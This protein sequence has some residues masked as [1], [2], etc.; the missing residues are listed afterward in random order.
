MLATP[1][2]ALF[3]SSVFMN[4]S[5]TGALSVAVGDALVYFPE[6]QKTTALITLVILMGALQLVFGLLRLGSLIRFVS[7]S[8]MTGFITGIA[9]LIILGA[10]PNLTGYHSPHHSEFLKLADTLL[11]LNQADPATLVVGLITIGLIVGFDYTPLRKFSMI[12]ALAVVTLLTFFLSPLLSIDSLD[13]VG[14]IAVIPRSMPLPILPDVTMVPTLILPALAIGII[15]LIQGAGVGQSYPNPDGKYPNVSR[16]FAGQ[17]LGNIAAGFFQGIPGGGSMS[18]T[19]VSVNAGAQSRWANILAGVFII[20]IVL[21]LADIVTLIPMAA[22]A[23]LLVVVGFQNLQPNKINIV[24]N[25]GLIARSAMVLTLLAT[26]SM[27]LQFAILVGVAISIMLYVF[28]SSN[29]IRVVEFVPV[30]SGF[31]EERPAPDKLVSHQITVL[32]PYGS[33]FFASASNFDQSLPKPED[34]QQSIV[35]IL[36]RGQPEVGSTFIEVLR[37][38]S[39]TLQKNG[40]KLMLAGVGPELRDQLARTGTM[41]LIGEENLFMEEAQLGAAMNN[42]LAAARSWMDDNALH[43]LDKEI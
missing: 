22:L 4:V 34:A 15:G 26:L 13:M 8:V 30:A 11:N 7:Q 39:E 43:P 6:A 41:T 36:L 20:L 10:L 38:Y 24:W 19:A 2:G 32:H 27:P 42:A 12:L 21:F 37:R 1:V 17:G 3:T 5:T 25:T 35:I 18:G 40:G 29:Q 9:L 23:G 31:P 28:Q 16:D 33:L 14:D